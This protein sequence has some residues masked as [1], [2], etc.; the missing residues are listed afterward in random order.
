VADLTLTDNEALARQEADHAEQERLAA[1]ARRGL[2]LLRES[3]SAN[4]ATFLERLATLRDPEASLVQLAAWAEACQLL[5]PQPDRLQVLAY[6]HTRHRAAS[7]A[8]TA[9]LEETAD[10]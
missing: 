6:T 5:L 7:K 4:L 2:A 8:V 1:T 9:W 10:A 3:I